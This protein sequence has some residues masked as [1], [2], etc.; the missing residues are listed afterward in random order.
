MYWEMLRIGKRSVTQCLN[1]NFLFNVNLQS[2]VIN[3][4]NYFK[5]F[6]KGYKQYFQYTA[7]YCTKEMESYYDILLF[8]GAVY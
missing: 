3:Q 4:S 5:V 6:M 7:E 2:I 8:N 1:R